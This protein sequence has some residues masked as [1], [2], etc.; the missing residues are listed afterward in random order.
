MALTPERV[1]WRRVIIPDLLLLGVVSHAHSNVVITCTT[2]HISG[3]TS[4]EM[5]T[6]W[7][8]P[9]DIERE[10]KASY[11]DTLSNLPSTVAKGM[12]SCCSSNESETKS[13]VGNLLASV[14][15]QAPMFLSVIV[16]RVIFVKPWC[17]RSSNRA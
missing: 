6:V 14:T 9:P 11:E 16:R 7:N 4:C 3:R 15:V 2:V 8:V 13:Q 10:F 12:L 17:R 1:D 5:G